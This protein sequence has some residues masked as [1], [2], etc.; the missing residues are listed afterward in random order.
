MLINAVENKNG[1]G[2]EERVEGKKKREGTLGRKKRRM[3]KREK[4]KNVAPL[5]T[6]S[7]RYPLYSCYY[8]LDLSLVLKPHLGDKTR[9]LAP[10]GFSA[11]NI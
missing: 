8:S 4:G 10:G 1:G 11:P 9:T 6:S 2:E 7:A 3:R 5:E